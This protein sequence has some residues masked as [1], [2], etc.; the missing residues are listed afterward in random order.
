MTH[1]F[2]CW[3]SCARDNNNGCN[4]IIITPWYFFLLQIYQEMIDND[5]VE[6]PSEPE[7]LL[8]EV[9]KMDAWIIL[10]FNFYP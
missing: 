8:L 9:Y 4:I 1:Y 6:G 10:I 7:K 2:Q 5:E 3:I